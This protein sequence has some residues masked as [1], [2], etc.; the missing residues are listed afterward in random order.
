MNTNLPGPSTPSPSAEALVVPA[1]YICTVQARS[2]PM[3]SRYCYTN[4]EVFVIGVKIIWEDQPLGQ[5]SLR[6]KCRGCRW[7]VV[8]P[9]PKHV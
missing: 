1:R 7:A 4:L 5:G 3:A 9:P 6:Q 8:R 2:T